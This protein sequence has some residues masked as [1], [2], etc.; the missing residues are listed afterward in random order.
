MQ[1][2]LVEFQDLKF[3]RDNYYFGIGFASWN[4]KGKRNNY[5]VHAIYR[6]TEMYENEETGDYTNG[7]KG[8]E[9][10]DSK[11]NVIKQ[12][13]VKAK[14]QVVS[15]QEVEDYIKKIEKIH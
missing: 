13:K 14:A 5:M 1:K 11:Y 12:F 2:T 8:F 4:V 10:L 3:E 6:D 9:L 7:I 15:V